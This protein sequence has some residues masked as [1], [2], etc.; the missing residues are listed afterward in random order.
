VDPLA[1][2][3]DI[4]G[5]WRPLNQAERDRSW[6]LLRLASSI[7]RSRVPTI[8]DR[9]AAGTLDVE[10]VRGVVVQMVVRALQNPGGARSKSVGAVSVT[11]DQPTSGLVLTEDEQA[12]LSPNR[13]P[14]IGTA[15][16]GAGLGFGECRERRWL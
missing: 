3:A 11:F 14:R 12:M 7:V 1:G 9:I 4:E 5:L 2:T 8:D 6:N 16:L 10:L 15:R 13:K